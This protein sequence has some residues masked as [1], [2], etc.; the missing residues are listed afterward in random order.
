MLTAIPRLRAFAVLLSGNEDQADDLVHETLLRANT[1]IHSLGPGTDIRA[2]LFMILRNQFYAGRQATQRGRVSV[3][4]Q[5]APR[6]PSQTATTPAAH[7]KLRQALTRLPPQ[8]REALIL[9]VASGLSYA[10]AALICGC[11]VGT[12]KSRVNRA[13]L[14]LARLMAI[15]E[16]S[17][18]D[19]SRNID[20]VTVRGRA[21]TRV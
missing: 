8:Q 14:D 11:P 10:E 21:G 15:E 3:A 17:D 5:A 6:A 13:R 12:I 18:L 9:V 1:D 7:D 2:W 20:A 4:D 16:S 19:E